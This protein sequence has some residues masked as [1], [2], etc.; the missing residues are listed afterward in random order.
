VNVTK[1]GHGISV[2]HVPLPF[3]SPKTVNCYLVEGD[4]GLTLIDCGVDWEPGAT[5]LEAGLLELGVELADITNLVV[6]HLH[7]DHVGM[8]PRV[9]A[10]SDCRFMMHE[11]ARS[12]IPRYNDTPGFAERLAALGRSNG[13]PSSALGEFSNIGPRPDFMP[14]LGAPDVTV[15]DGDSIEVSASRRLEVIYTPGHDQAH[16]C[17]RDSLTGI[18]FSG[19]HVL[20]RITP[21]IMF[22]EDAG[23]V[24]GDYMTSLQR[25]IDT[26]IGLTYPAHGHVIER[27]RQRCEQILLHHERRL[28]GMLEVLE[29][30]PTT[31]W[32]IMLASFRPN[33]NPLEQRLALR[34]TV[35]HLEHLRISDSVDTFEE[36]GTIWYRLAGTGPGFP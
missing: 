14:T 15:E 2:V 19:D 30:G 21:V 11:S 32:E 35:A 8:A 16:I 34:E 24:L 20:G 12:L 5:T 29:R 31:A 28:S 22:S 10:A 33:L 4:R 23:D 13:V 18:V 1:L 6:R 7:P 36:D 17:L 25:L 27:G 9:I 26:R 3:Q